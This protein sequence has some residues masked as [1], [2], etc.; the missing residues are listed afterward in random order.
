[1]LVTFVGG[2]VVDQ[3]STTTLG[4]DLSNKPFVEPS[5]LMEAALAR[6]MDLQAQ[7]ASCTARSE[8]ILK[9]E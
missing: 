4:A 6:K 2:D 1:M 7:A 5:K 9:I 3:T 8:F